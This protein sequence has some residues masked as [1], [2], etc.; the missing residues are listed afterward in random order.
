MNQAKQ[1]LR[2]KIW[3]LLETTQAA[4]FPLPCYGRIPNFKGVQRATEKL[5]EWQP[6]KDAKCVFSAPDYVLRRARE[7]VLVMEKQL[8][9]ATPHMR[10]FLMLEN[11]PV[12]K[13]KEAVTI[14]GFHRF[15]KKLDEEVLK[16]VIDIF[17]QG[18]VAVDMQG[19]R[20][21]KGKGYGDKE[22]WFLA[23]KG[24]LSSDCQVVSIVHDLQVVENF[25]ALVSPEDVKVNCILTPTRMILV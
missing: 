6:F 13:I 1:K 18:S 16:G 15:G 19:N 21:G 4:D 11:V 7:L 20:L 5:L 8:I 9:V 23:C 24:L 2:E 10:A 22:Y 12:A 17:L 3:H 14:K 25:S